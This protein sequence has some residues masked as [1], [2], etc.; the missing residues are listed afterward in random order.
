[1]DEV[2]TKLE[3]TIAARPEDREARH[4]LGVL[5]AQAG[6]VA[7]GYVHCFRSGLAVDPELERAAAEEQVS[8]LRALA[9]QLPGA[10]RVAVGEHRGADAESALYNTSY[11][12][13]PRAQLPFDLELDWRWSP[14]EA[15]LQ[16]SPGPPVL[17]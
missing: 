17:R 10:V 12:W 13:V 4:R 2:L 16:T 5:L 3:R 14:L 7:E 15:H 11:G 8:A 6:R 1:M 9:E